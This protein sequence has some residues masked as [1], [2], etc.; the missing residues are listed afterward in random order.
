LHF[1]LRGPAGRGPHRDGVPPASLPPEELNRVGFRLYERFWPEVPEGA[2]GWGAKGGVAGG[3]ECWGD[4]VGPRRYSLP[5]HYCNCVNRR[6]DPRLPLIRVVQLLQ[7]GP[8][9]LGLPGCMG[10]Q[11]MFWELAHKGPGRWQTQCQQTLAK[12]CGSWR[13]QAAQSLFRSTSSPP[14]RGSHPTTRAG[15]KRSSCSSGLIP[16]I[17]RI[18]P[19]APHTSSCRRMPVSTAF[20]AATN[21][22]RRYRP[23]PA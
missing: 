12:P 8:S 20:V 23:S 15:L 18:D 13:G 1:C 11:T 16:G 10:R 17:R 7:S 4:R 9:M 5:R 19:P 6:I 22:S 14:G 3:A 2:Q 21:R